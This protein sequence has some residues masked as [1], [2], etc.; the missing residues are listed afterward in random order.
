MGYEHDTDDQDYNAE[1]DKRMH[2][3]TFMKSCKTYGMLAD[4][5]RPARTISNY[6]TI[7]RILLKQTMDPKETYYFRMK[8]VLDNDRKEFQMDYLEYCPKEVYDN[9]NEPEDIW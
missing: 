5:S 8:S 1:V 4:A 9:P 7:R 2:N 6:T 3:N